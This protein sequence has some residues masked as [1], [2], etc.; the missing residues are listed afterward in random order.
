[1]HQIKHIRRV[2]SRRL[3]RN[4][5]RSPSRCRCALCLVHRRCRF[6][7]SRRQCFLAGCQRGIGRRMTTVFACPRTLGR[8]MP[9]RPY[10]TPKP[11]NVR[12]HTESPPGLSQT[13]F[14]WAYRSTRRRAELTDGLFG[15]SC[16]P[17]PTHVQ[18]SFVEK[19]VSSLLSPP[20]PCPSPGL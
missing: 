2:S 12:S 10:T 3:A 14:A 7:Y 20:R 5:P 15:M 4:A 6:P 19:V 16:W 1:M 9:T 11:A 13:L 17:R 8:P 18:A